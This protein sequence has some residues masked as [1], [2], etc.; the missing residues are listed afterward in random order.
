[1]AS[2]LHLG[3]IPLLGLIGILWARSRANR[4]LLPPG[5]RGVPLL[6]NVLGLPKDYGWLHWA[7]FKDA[8]GPISSIYVMGQPIIIL[9]SL[10]ACEDLLKR[11]SPIY[12]GRPVLQ[13]AGEMV[14]WSLQMILSPYN[15]RFRSM[16]KL[17]AR[18]I[19]TNVAVT[20]FRPV[21][22]LEMRY[23]LARVCENQDN[24]LEDIRL[25]TAAV[26]LKISYGY[27]VE[28]DKTDPLLVLIDTAAHEFYLATLPGT[29]AVDSFPFL[30]Y[31]PSW[32]PGSRFKKVAERYRKTIMESTLKPLAF[33]QRCM[34][35][36]TEVSSFSSILLRSELDPLDAEVLPCAVA[37]LFG[38]GTDTIAA[39]ISTFIL[40]MVL[41]PDVQRKAQEELDR[42]VG[43]HRLPN[44]DD[45]DH[46]PYLAAVYKEL[47]R[48]HVIGPMGIPHYATA[49]DWYEGYF[50]PKG[51]LIMS[52]LWQIANDASVYENPSDFLPE[53]FLG[54]DSP[55]DPHTFVFGFGRRECPGAIF[56]GASLYI[57]MSASLATLNFEPMPEGAP[58]PE[59]LSGTIRRVD[60]A[61]VADSHPKPFKCNIK[62][63]SPDALQIIR[64]VYSE[65]PVL[66]PASQ[67]SAVY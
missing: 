34:V 54:A 10:Q 28:R 65:H 16:R 14:G 2:A 51:S 22:E 33:A 39:T 17:V 32:V 58:A 15:D 31:L 38:G 19:G 45:R 1:M 26:F 35:D 11:R 7:K 25:M 63:R 46:L 61:D 47:L 8:Y 6:G 55:L 42:V 13:F 29:W 56:A 49:D 4:R 53:R 60:N 36:G 9:N 64:A 37:S 44:F 52:N 3:W 18:H 67:L 27:T 23:F 12:S 48:W 40:A 62:P 43:R 50:I 24:F 30:R 59:F 66:E 20:K 21:Q 5:P 57:F 41:F